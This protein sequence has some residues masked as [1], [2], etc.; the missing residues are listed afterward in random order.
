MWRLLRNL[1]A[2]YLQ[3]SA[4]LFPRTP[5]VLR[6]LQPVLTR[7]ERARGDY[8]LLPLGRL[9]AVEEGKLGERFIAQAAK[10]YE[11]IVEDCEINFAKEIEFETFREN[12]SYEEAEEIRL[13]F[14]KIEDWMRRAKRLDWFGAP[15]AA[16]AEAWLARCEHMLEEFEA[17][18]YRRQ[19][20]YSAG[21]SKRSRRSRSATAVGEIEANP[22]VVGLRDFK[23]NAVARTATSPPNRRL[24]SAT[25]GP[26]IKER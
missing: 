19:G 9:D 25:N 5:A 8:H 1:G 18:V 10:R 6:E 20:E 26:D 4:C 22:R 16:D 11:E 17:E 12:F 3:Q 13:E 23:L 7:I 14:E 15:N 24:R 21:A 2:V